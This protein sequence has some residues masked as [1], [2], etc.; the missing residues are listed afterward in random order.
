MWWF[1]VFQL[2]FPAE[3]AIVHSREP[4]TAS[5]DGLNIID[6]PRDPSE[7]T[8]ETFL[9][10]LDRSVAHARYWHTGCNADGGSVGLEG[11][12]S[13]LDHFDLGRNHAVRNVV[14]KAN[15]TKRFAEAD[16]YLAGIL[17]KLDLGGKPRS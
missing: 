5:G 11:L 15:D 8:P 7:Q 17:G 4:D 3:D 9:N 12:Q 14:D 16:A 1:W 10:L 2:N 13:M 6:A